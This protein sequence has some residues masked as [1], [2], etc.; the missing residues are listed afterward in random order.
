MHRE[1]LNN[2]LLQAARDGDEHF[3]DYLLERGADPNTQSDYFKDKIIHVATDLGNKGVLR[4]LLKQ[5][6]L[7]VNAVNEFG[8][9]ALHFAVQHH[10]ELVDL[11]LTHKKI[12]VNAADKDGFT[13]LYYAVRDKKQD[14]VRKLL[15]DPRIEI[16]AKTKELLRER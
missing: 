6:R 4:A 9:T 12:D 11:L 8:K 1:K 13:P 7:D 3:T 14:V 15:E 10:N 2:F 5:K 16:D